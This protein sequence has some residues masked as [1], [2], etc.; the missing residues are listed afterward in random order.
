[1]PANSRWD[2]IKGLKCFEIKIIL[3][4]NS[5]KKVY[6]SFQL[7]NHQVFLTDPVQGFTVNKTSNSAY[8]YFVTDVSAQPIRP[9]FKGPTVQER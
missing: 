3:V 6:F 7:K 8:G 2:L 5:C 9:I 4:I 1:M